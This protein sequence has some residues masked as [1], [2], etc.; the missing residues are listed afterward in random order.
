MEPV[1]PLRE[2]LGDLVGAGPDAAPEQALDQ[3]GHG[4]LPGGLVAEAVAS[5]ADTAPVEVAEHLAPFVTAYRTS[6]EAA[7]PGAALDL[8]VSA[9]LPA[10]DQPGSE[11]SLLATEAEAA[12]EAAEDPG[13]AHADGLDFGAGDLGAGDQFDIEP[14]P[15][16]APEPPPGA[17]TGDLTLDFASTGEEEYPPQLWPEISPPQPPD[18][19]DPGIDEP[20]LDPV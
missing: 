18:L 2:V 4:G 3:A 7:D 6:G 12:V 8:L 10:A 5:Y 1:R 20:G 19:D 9:P 13:P 16:A 15:A 14:A 11:S 17:E